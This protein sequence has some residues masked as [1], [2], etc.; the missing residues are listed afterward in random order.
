MKLFRTDNIEVVNSLV[1]FE[2]SLLSI[3]IG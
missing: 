3:I 2:F 1:C